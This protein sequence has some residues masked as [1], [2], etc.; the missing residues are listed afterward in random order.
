MSEGKIGISWTDQ[1]MNSLVGCRECSKGCENCYARLRIY[2]FSK[3]EVHNRDGRYSDL[4]ET[5]T[6]PAVKGGVEQDVEKRRFTGRILFNPAKLYACF[7]FKSGSLVFVDEFSDL[8]HRAVPMEVILEH[9]RVFGVL[10][11]CSSRS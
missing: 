11:G 3:S 2:R 1:A 4:V 8:L 5:Y 6:M 10:H 9:F 7:K